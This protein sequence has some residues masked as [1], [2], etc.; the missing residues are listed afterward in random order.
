MIGLAKNRADGKQDH[1]WNR[2]VFH[3]HSRDP[4][5]PRSAMEM[6]RGD[7][8]QTVKEF[9]SKR[10]QDDLKRYKDP[11]ARSSSTLRWIK[12]VCVC[13]KVSLSEHDVMML[14]YK[15]RTRVRRYSAL[16][17]SAGIH[18]IHLLAAVQLKVV[19]DYYDVRDAFITKTAH[20]YLKQPFATGKSPLHPRPVSPAH[21][22]V[23]H[24]DLRHVRPDDTYRSSHAA[25]VADSRGAAKT[26]VVPPLDLSHVFPR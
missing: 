14:A 16:Q 25:S 3:K 8:F 26:H 24:E 12:L 17:S 1:A 19:Q 7:V 20:Q 15:S 5:R 10:R 23:F 2:S 21:A 6:G 18:Y 13:A 11:V 22:G 9:S 4:C